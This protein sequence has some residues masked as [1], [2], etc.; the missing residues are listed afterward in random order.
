MYTNE[1]YLY[2]NCKAAQRRITC[3]VTLAP[4]QLKT[5][6]ACRLKE[7]L[8][9]IYRNSDT[10]VANNSEVTAHWDGTLRAF[11]A[12]HLH[13][14]YVEAGSSLLQAAKAR[15]RGYGKTG[16]F[17][18]MVLLSAVKL[19]HLLGNPLQKAGA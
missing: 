4:Y 19:A 3:S 18:A 7:A 16:H 17:I 14:G 5:A 15:V 2:S 10:D 12:F 8:R 6:R 13:T 1:N 9:T 11:N